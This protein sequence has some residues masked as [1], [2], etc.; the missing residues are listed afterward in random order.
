MEAGGNDEWREAGTIIVGAQLI[1]RTS[2][3]SERT[4]IHHVDYEQCAQLGI[5]SA[6][7]GAVRS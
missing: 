4:A 7:P 5:T 3:H 6:G 1:R 2:E